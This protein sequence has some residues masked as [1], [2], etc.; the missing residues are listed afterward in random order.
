MIYFDNNASTAVDPRVIE[1]MMP[2]FIE[3]WANPSNGK[4]RL[5]RLAQR[6]IDQAGREVTEF[7]GLPAYKTLFTSSATESNLSVLLSLEQSRYKNSKVFCG[8][9]EHNSLAA[10]FRRASNDTNYFPP[11]E[12]G[13]ID[14]ASVKKAKISENDCVFLQWVN[15]ETGAVNPIKEI[16]EY[17]RSIGCF[18]HVD[19]TQAP[20]KIVIEPDAIP[21]CTSLTISAHKIYGPKGVSALI[22]Q[23]S[24]PF[25]PLLNGG[26]GRTSNRAGT[27][28]VPGIVGLS[29]AL[30]LIK[31]EQTQICKHQSSL[32]KSL[33]SKLTSLSYACKVISPE[34]ERRA[35]N[36]LMLSWPKYPSKGI[37]QELDRRNICVSAGSACSSEK[38]SMS[39]T[40][41]RLN[42]DEAIGLGAIRFSVGKNNTH[43][44]ID[45]VV[46]AMNQILGDTNLV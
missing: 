15:S 8:P 16:S 25:L 41:E 19:A 42:M 44:E 24:F 6:A 29:T 4:Y 46:D 27:E 9:L 34:I 3:N 2:W 45:E 35:T 39:D 32:I 18:F 33:Q 17:L 23:R 26:V 31:S 28:N 37:L 5:G 36:T 38:K 22:M 21:Y 20:G 30:N 40:L 12:E 10:N 43:E 13:I 11:N 7:F 14:V 1:A